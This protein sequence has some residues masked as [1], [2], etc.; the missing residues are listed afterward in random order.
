MDCST[1]SAK[2]LKLRT[3]ILSFLTSAR[4]LRADSVTDESMRIHQAIDGKSIDLKTS[5]LDEVLFRSDT[6]GRDFLQVNFNSKQKILITEKLIG[7]KPLSAKGI[8]SS[9]LPRVV[10]TPDVLSVFEAIQ[11]ALHA[12]QPDDA[13]IAILKRVYDAVLRGGENIGFDLATERSWVARIP[14]F[15]TKTAA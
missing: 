9:K 11:D 12:A 4:G 2:Q 1:G 8:D 14:S 5:S 15:I 7:F 3:D 10:T 13:E 6:E